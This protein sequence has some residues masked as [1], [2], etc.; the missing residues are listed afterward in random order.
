M[1]AEIKEQWLKD[2]RSGDFAQVEG[3]LSDGEGYCCLGVLCEQAVKAG[4]IE[5]TPTPDG[6]KYGNDVEFSWGALP[7]PVIDWAELD[8]VDPAVDGEISYEDRDGED[9]RDQRSHLDRT[10]D[11]RLCAGV[12]RQPR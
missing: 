11:A 3:T 1:K 7:Q 6:V 5:K 2:L 8:S 12:R 9:R 10:Q 4:V